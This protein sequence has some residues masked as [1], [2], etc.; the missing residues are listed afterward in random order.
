MDLNEFAVALIGHLD[1]IATALEG[2]KPVVKSEPAFPAEK[3]AEPV[4]LQSAQKILIEYCRS[5]DNGAGKVMQFLE[6]HQAQGL[7]D[8]SASERVELIHHIEA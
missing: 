8:L 1:R 7:E 5:N 3:P 2:N 4:T 6:A